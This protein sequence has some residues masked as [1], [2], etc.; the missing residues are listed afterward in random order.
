MLE[1]TILDVVGVELWNVLANKHDDDLMF[2]VSLSFS[3]LVQ[4]EFGPV[5]ESW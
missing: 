2:I 5:G 3:P 4:L 1:Q